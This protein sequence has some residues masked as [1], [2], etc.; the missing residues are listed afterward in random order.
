LIG[1]GFCFLVVA[2]A[3]QRFTVASAGGNQKPETRNYDGPFWFLVSGF[4]FNA[5]ADVDSPAAHPLTAAQLRGKA[6][7]LRGESTTGH[8]VTAV[9][10]EEGDAVPAAVV[11][12]ANCHGED[13]RG[14]PEGGVRPPDITPESRARA[15][16]VNSRKRPAY[17]RPLLKRA[18]TMGFDSGR[19]VLNIAMPRYQLVMQDA[20]DLLAYL[21]I[22]GHEPQ[23]GV[24][25]DAIRIKLAGDPGP[26]HA[27]EIYGR[28]VELVHDGEAFLTIDAS[29]DSRA[30]VTAAEHDHIP[31]LVVSAP[32]GTNPYTF[33]L[34]AGDDEQRAALR[35]FA[36][37]QEPVQESL[38]QES[39]M[40]D[41]DC[42]A[43]LGR[44]AA[45]PHPPLV[46]MTAAVAKTCDLAT[47]PIAL[48]RRI[49]VAAPLPPT[50]DATRNATAAAVA[51]ATNLLSQLGRDVTRATFTTALEHVYKLDTSSLP[52]ITWDA[53]H[54]GTRTAW[55]MTVDVKAQRLL[56]EPGWVAGE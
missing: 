13:G 14:K 20:E 30:S 19:S 12:C 53:N 15:T 6:I 31:T 25:G 16:E 49:I 39:L 36:H 54:H 21:E 10:S 48:D 18:I 42:M 29:D 17:S 33:A 47:I 45:L 41:S 3:P 51:I 43:A 44:A 40:I 35:A 28:K 37:R 27:G 5:S 50:P 2:S 52:P 22:V 34:T 56:A 8:P 32:A 46:L 11:P 1:F 23:P 38:M 24:S 7:Y 4:W 9:L 55:L 26:L